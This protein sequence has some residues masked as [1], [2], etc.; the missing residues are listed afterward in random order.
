MPQKIHACIHTPEE[1]DLETHDG[2]VLNPNVTNPFD[3][4][5]YKIL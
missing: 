1:K 2:M 3:R 5:I 4:I